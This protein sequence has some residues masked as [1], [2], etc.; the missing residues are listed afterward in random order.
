MNM[1]KYWKFGSHDDHVENIIHMK[2]SRVKTPPQSLGENL[3]VIGDI[4]PGPSFKVALNVFPAT[5]CE[6][7]ASPHYGYPQ[8][9]NK[10]A[11]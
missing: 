9:Q 2:H 8:K 11:Y 10:V 4:Y 1:K 7:S 5:R 3:S 6:Q